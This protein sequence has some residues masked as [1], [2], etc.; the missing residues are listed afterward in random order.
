MATARRCG[1]IGVAGLQDSDGA[2]LVARLWENLKAMIILDDNNFK[3]QNEKP[4]SNAGV[5]EEF[6]HQVDEFIQQ[7]R[8][9]LEELAKKVESCS[10]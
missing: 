7:Y 10:V 6:I 3:N 5:D 8:S 4:E 2:H 1:S 9:A